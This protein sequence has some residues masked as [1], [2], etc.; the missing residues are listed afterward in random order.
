MDC[1]G[2][3]GGRAF[4]LPP[5]VRRQVQHSWWCSSKFILGDLHSAIWH[6]SPAPPNGPINP[7][8]GVNDKICHEADHPFRPVFYG[9]CDLHGSVVLA[10]EQ[11][12]SHPPT[13]LALATNLR[14]NHA[15]HLWAPSLDLFKGPKSEKVV[16][17]ITCLFPKAKVQM[18][19][20][21]RLLSP[22]K[23]TLPR[24][25]YSY[26]HQDFRICDT[27]SCYGKANGVVLSSEIVHHKVEDEATTALLV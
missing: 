5:W 9:L 27:R 2:P 20:V 18:W 10:L 23:T 6:I 7:R 3:P 13:G 16:E 21:P 14:R 8:T 22:H 25:T 26:R 11:F 17:W 24:P 4:Q 1:T 12:A 19:T 15:P